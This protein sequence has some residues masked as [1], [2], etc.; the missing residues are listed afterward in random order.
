LY[1]LR[2]V[3]IAGGESTSVIE[4]F[5]S[6]SISPNG[7]EVATYSTPTP[8]D[9]K[10]YTVLISIADGHQ[11]RVAETPPE[12]PQFV[13]SYD[14]KSLQYIQADAGTSNIWEQLLSGAAPRRI[15]NFSSQ[16]MFSFARS[17][18]GN[19]LA[20]ARGQTRSDVV[21]ISNFR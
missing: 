1:D 16:Q 2:K 4:N 6:S 13:W 18:T 8:S 17:G 5:W 20:M 10:V 12:G 19:H 21:L 11:T 7:N 14:G 9:P 15:S 3:P